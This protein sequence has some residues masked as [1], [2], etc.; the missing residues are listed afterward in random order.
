MQNKSLSH[1]WR[2]SKQGTA[3]VEGVLFL[4]EGIDIDPCRK[5]NVGVHLEVSLENVSK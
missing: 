2:F 3:N 4:I 5:K 1:A